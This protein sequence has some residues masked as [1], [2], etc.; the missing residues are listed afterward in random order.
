MCATMTVDRRDPANPVIVSE[1]PDPEGGC[2]LSIDLHGSVHCEE[3]DCDG[4]C[5]QEPVKEIEPKVFLHSCCCGIGEGSGACIDCNTAG[6]GDT[7][8][9]GGGH[10]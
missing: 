9:V 1:Q 5:G 6:S 2:V 3:L 7:L 4:F 8:D 10:G